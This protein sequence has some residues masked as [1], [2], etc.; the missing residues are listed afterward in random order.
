MSSKPTHIAHVVT[1]PREGS[2]KKAVWTRVG[3]VFPHKNGGGFDIVIP[4][5][6]S[7]SG[8][9]V[10]TESKKDDGE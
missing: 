5:G 4:D 1:N 6:I 2:D 8:R 3:A 9:I 10:C 7:L